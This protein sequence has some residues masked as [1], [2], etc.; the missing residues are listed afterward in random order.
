[1]LQDKV[2]SEEEKNRH[3][4]EADQRIRK[5]VSELEHLRRKGRDISGFCEEIRNVFA[6]TQ[7]EE[8]A[9][10]WESKLSSLRDQ[11]KPWPDTSELALASVVLAIREQ[12]REV[13][14]SQE[15]MNRLRGLE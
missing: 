3:F 5:A 4:F 6:G 1:M 15:E 9:T 13:R 7:A 2:L 8:M 11:F 10:N 12:L 14:E